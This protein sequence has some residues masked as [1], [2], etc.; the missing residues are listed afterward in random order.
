MSGVGCE[1]WKLTCQGGLDCRYL[2]SELRP[3]K[4]KIVSVT[5][6]STPHRGSP[7]ADYLIDNIVGRKSAPSPLH[8][9]RTTADTTCPLITARSASVLTVKAS[10]SPPS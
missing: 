3:T 7:F 2:I 5:T 9:S 4:F 6:I 8:P 1:G 10:A